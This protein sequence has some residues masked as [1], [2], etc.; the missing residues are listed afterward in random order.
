M[1]LYHFDEVNKATLPLMT[2]RNHLL[3]SLALVFGFLMTLILFLKSL[4]S[5]SK[6]F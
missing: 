6:A 4:P 1:L 5:K 2:Y 3:Y